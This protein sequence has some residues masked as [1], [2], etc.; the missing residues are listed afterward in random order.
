[1]GPRTICAVIAHYHSAIKISSLAK[2]IKATVFEKDK[3]LKLQCYVTG[4][5]AEINAT[6]KDLKN[7]GMLPFNPPI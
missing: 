1:M 3:S 6:N 5:T 4:R 2:G 7:E